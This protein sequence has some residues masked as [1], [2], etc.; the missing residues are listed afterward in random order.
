MC[1][2][3]SERPAVGAEA[4]YGAAPSVDALSAGVGSTWGV[5]G[6]TGSDVGSTC[7]VSAAG[8]VDVDASEAAAS[9]ESSLDPPHAATTRDSAKMT[10]YAVPLC[11]ILPPLVQ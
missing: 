5:T 6:D 3:G 8:C 2:V 10:A 11:N 7:G 9:V 4:L 1:S